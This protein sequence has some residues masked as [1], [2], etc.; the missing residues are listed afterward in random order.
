MK[1]LSGYV[2]L[3]V[4]V[5]ASVNPRAYIRKKL[6]SDYRSTTCKHATKVGRDFSGFAHFRGGKT[7]PIPKWSRCD[8]NLSCWFA[9]Q[10]YN[11][12]SVAVWHNILTSV[13]CLRRPTQLLHRVLNLLCL[14]W[15]RLSSRSPAEI[16]RSLEKV[17]EYK[18]FAIFLPKMPNKPHETSLRSV[19]EVS[20]LPSVNQAITNFIR[21]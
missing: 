6:F 14:I 18:Q 2:R 21:I 12:L 17:L 19:L 11:F 13:S 20:T 5:H 8:T 16:D 4:C 3:S 7:N 10:P 9:Y 15:F 1:P